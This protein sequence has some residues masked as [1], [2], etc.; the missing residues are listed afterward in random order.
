M[1][2]TKPAIV[3]RMLRDYLGEDVFRAGLR[4]YYADNLLTHVTL[5][6][7]QRAM[8]E[9]S[10]ER[11]DWFF[12]QWF[13]TTATLD[14][15]VTD[16]TTTQDDDGRWT[17]RVTVERRGEAWMPVVL[18]VDGARVTL[19]SRERVQTVEVTTDERP[20]AAVVDP[21]RVLLD[22][23]RGNNRRRWW[24]NRM[25]IKVLDCFG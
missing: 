7:F 14:Y 6:D 20:R 15:A 12:N 1:T 11:L 21:E 22:M 3:Y 13:R 19:E 17:T 24:G 4:R 5:A 23:D 16:A 9:A 10:G 2:Y 8:E 25:K 18:E